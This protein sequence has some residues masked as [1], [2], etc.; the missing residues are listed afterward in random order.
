MKKTQK[1]IPTVIYNM[2]TDLNIDRDFR[3]RIARELGIEMPDDHEA[4]FEQ[5]R[6]DKLLEDAYDVEQEQKANYFNNLDK[7]EQ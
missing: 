4:E 6:N 1:E 5:C 3:E 2:L 7:D